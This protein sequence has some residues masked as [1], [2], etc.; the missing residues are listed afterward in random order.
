MSSVLGKAEVRSL[1]DLE[2]ATVRRAAK[3][4]AAAQKAQRGRKLKEPASEVPPPS[5]KVVRIDEVIA[6]DGIPATL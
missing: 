5:S 1:E 6:S 4:K 3:D 2:E